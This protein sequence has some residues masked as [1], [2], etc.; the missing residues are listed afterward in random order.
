MVFLLN[1]IKQSYITQRYSL[2]SFKSSRGV[3]VEF[4][5]KENIM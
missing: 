4:V 5:E 2:D 1:E 3:G